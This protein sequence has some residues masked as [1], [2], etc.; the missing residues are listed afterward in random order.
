MKRFQ[1]WVVRHRRQKDSKANDADGSY[2]SDSRRES[3]V[4]PTLPAT[5]QRAVSSAGTEA[6]QQQSP[7]FTK[8][9][10]ELRDRIYVQAFGNR[11]IHIDLSHD[12]ADFAGDRHAGLSGKFYK[13]Q[14]TPRQWRWWSCTCHRLQHVKDG[15]QYRLDF[16][17]DRCRQAEQTYCRF[18]DLQLDP[19]ECLVGAMGWL[20]SCRQA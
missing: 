15:K 10:T 1:S 13:D 9:P 7:F 19:S 14:S 2:A 17:L 16:W 11:T 3:D 20:L 8:L 6:T 4:M 5:R 12:H 18:E